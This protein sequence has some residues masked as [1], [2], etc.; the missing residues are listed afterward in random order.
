M[1]EFDKKKLREI[2]KKSENLVEELENL[3]KIANERICQ[4]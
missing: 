4:C 3:K 1:R 2:L